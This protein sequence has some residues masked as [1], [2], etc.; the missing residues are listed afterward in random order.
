LGNPGVHTPGII[1]YGFGALSA[2]LTA[3][4]VPFFIPPLNGIIAAA[5]AYLI[6]DLTL[7]R[8]GT[9]KEGRL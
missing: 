6:L 2:W 3:T 4:V 5:A 8:K 7:G 1:A 9:K